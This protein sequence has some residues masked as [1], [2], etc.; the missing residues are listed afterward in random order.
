MIK[1]GLIDKAR[2]ILKDEPKNI[3]HVTFVLNR[4][5]V[6]CY[7]INKPH[8]T[9]PLA[10]KFGHRSSCIHSELA[11]ILK[12]PHAPKELRKYTFVNIRVMAN[13]S[14]GMSKPCKHCQLLLMA[15]GIKNV[16]WT[17]KVGEFEQ[18]NERNY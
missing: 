9:S 1:Q 11:A 16:W 13:G 7:G 2:Q 3:K 18:S 5:T 6:I 8:K 15:F 10:K 14:I 12:F 4:G 17:N